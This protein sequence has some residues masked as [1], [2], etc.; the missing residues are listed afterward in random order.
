VGWGLHLPIGGGMPIAPACADGTAVAQRRTRR[1][2]AKVPPIRPAPSR[3]NKR[4]G[5]RRVQAVNYGEDCSRQVRA[6]VRGAALE[7]AD[8]ARGRPP[9]RSN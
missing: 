9:C 4:L 3:Y 7:W 8:L 2:P 5:Q 1:Q 6:G